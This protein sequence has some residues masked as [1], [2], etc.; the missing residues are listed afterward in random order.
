MN[1]ISIRD[2]ISKKVG[3]RYARSKELVGE[4]TI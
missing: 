3:I 1:K 4:F 2:I